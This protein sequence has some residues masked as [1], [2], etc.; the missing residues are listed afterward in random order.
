M[1]RKATVKDAVTLPGAEARALAE[2]RH[3]DPFSVLGPHGEVARA[4]I[5]HIARLWL[6]QGRAKPKEMRRHPDAGEVFEG[7][8]KADEPYSY[9]AEADDGTV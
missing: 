5:P 4:V 8:V 9:R 6:L 3:G 7:P 2:G 1:A